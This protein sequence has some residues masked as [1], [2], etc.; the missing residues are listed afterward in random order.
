[1]WDDK[2][3]TNMMG[4]QSM[5]MDAPHAEMMTQGGHLYIQTNELKNGIIHYLRSP[6]GTITESERALT[7]GAGSGGYNPIVDK[8]TPNNFEGARSVILSPDHRFLFA[9]NAGDNSVSSFSVSDDGKLTLLDAKRTGNVVPG[10]SGSAKSLAY[11][12]STSTLFVCHA[13]GPDHIRLI[14]VSKEGRLTARAERYTVNTADKIDRVA[15]MVTLSPDGK[16]LVVGTTFD[17][18]A[19]PNP[20]GSPILWV[21]RDGGAPHSVASNAPDPD[22]LAVFPVTGHGALGPCLLQ[23]GGGGSPW[24]PHF[25]H[26][27]P[28]TLVIGYAVADGLA[29]A[30]INEDGQVATGPVVKI[31]TSLGLPSELCW[32][33]VSPDDKW[34]FATNFGY[35][36]VTSYRLEG[37]VLSV[38]KDPACAKVPGN[39][40]F[41]ALNG[42][43]SS[44]PSDNWLTDDGAYFYQVYGNASKLVGYAVQSDGSLEEITSADIP[45]NSSQGLV[46]F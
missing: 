30:T 12:A 32:L 31:D 13:L 18:P 10:R 39:G 16:F 36:Y 46:G 21:S 42:T 23:D 2:T 26:N 9:T 41:R 34:V 24:F 20:D 1:M 33:S 45:Y 17:Q 14:A 4:E 25:L 38:A 28:D 8:E 29:L 35:S 6:N 19:K 7:G 11:D 3:E 27:R 40:T 22:G 43:V 44:G 15:T 37:N 5:S